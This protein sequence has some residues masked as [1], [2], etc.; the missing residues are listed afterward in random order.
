M[1]R[2]PLSKN[3]PAAV[4][5]VVLSL[6]PY[7]GL[8]A[9]V[10]PLTDVIAKSL[11]LSTSVL[12]I[13]MSV[14]AGAYSLGTVLAV[15]LAVHLPARRMLVIYEAIFVAASVLAASATDGGVFVVA[16]V[17]QGLCTSLMLI[18]AVPPL[19]TAWP[20]QKMPITAGIMNLC[21][22]GAVA[23]GPTVGAL[24]L[25]GSQWR[26]L[27]WVVAGLA[28][29]ALLFSL[30]TFED[31]PA[32]D[33]SSPW[34]L[35]ALSFSVIGCAAAF[36]GAGALQ[37]GRTAN[38]ASVVPLIVGAVLLVA[39]VV[40]EYRARRPLMPVKAVATSVPTTGIFIALSTSAAA[41][42]LMELTLQMLKHMKP[43]S[44]PA[45]TALLFLPEFGGAVLVAGVFA[46]LFRTRFVPVLAMG[47][48]LLVVASAGVLLA[49]MPT[50]G[51][52]VAVSTG[53]LG[54]GVGASVSPALF[55]A[56][57][58]LP[59]KLLQRVFAMIELTRGVTA[60]LVAPILIFLAGVMGATSMSGMK[61]AVWICLAIAGFGFVG[62]GA[63]YLTGRPWLEVPDLETWQGGADDPAWHS[64]P[65]WAAMRSRAATAGQSPGGNVPP[66]FDLR[67]REAEADRT[68]P[69]VRQPAQRE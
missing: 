16:F 63:L 2:G 11:H 43:A 25:T 12:Y 51:P 57:L 47:G 45:H 62:A 22:F 9:A 68:P 3:Y 1:P 65:L 19:V 66:R 6:V 54:L 55:M 41:F 31:Q 52:A 10:I 8:I 17:A 24:Q 37:S 69:Q 59:A 27:F 58:S 20:A 60:F 7:L 15:Q 13:A 49:T 36:Y 39:L 28:V 18:A 33:R 21:I 46:L 23:V 42:G 67:D 56:G 38:F 26:P 50:K 53:L 34:D 64:P 61:Y 30:L 40:Y 5:L 4:A 35:V 14:S 29:L 32:L 48:L 44:S